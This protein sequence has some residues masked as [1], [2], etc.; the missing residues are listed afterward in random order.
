V[1]KDIIPQYSLMNRDI[2]IDNNQQGQ[3]IPYVDFVKTLINVEQR[4]IRLE[5]RLNKLEI[6]NSIMQKQLTS[7]VHMLELEGWI[8][9][10]QLFSPKG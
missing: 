6:D 1:K 2:V 9:D 4:T 10:E 7:I 3:S 8:I 5:Q